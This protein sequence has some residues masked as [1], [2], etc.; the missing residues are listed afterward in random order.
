MR[1]FCCQPIF[2]NGHKFAE[3]NKLKLTKHYKSLRQTDK[4]V[5]S[6]KRGGDKC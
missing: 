5:V 4:T 3:D 2:E 1:V 6:M